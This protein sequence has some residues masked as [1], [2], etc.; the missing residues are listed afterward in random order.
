M[1]PDAY[2]RYYGNDF[3]SATK[4]W[5][6]EVKWAYWS[7]L[8]YYRSHTHCTG[9][10]D[11]NDFLRR[12]CECDA[13][14]WMRTKGLIFDN[15]RFF[16]LIDGKWHQLRAARD[17]ADDC[18]DYKKQCER[19]EKARA[20]NPDNQIGQ[21]R[22]KA[23][24]GS[25]TAPVTGPVTGQQPEPEPEPEPKEEQESFDKASRRGSSSSEKKTSNH[26]TKPKKLSER[27]KDIADK[28]EACLGDE[29]VN[30]AGKWIGRIKSDTGKAER[31]ANEVA[32]A[33]REGRIA[34]T[35]ARYAEDTWNRFK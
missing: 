14:D 5:R 34:T 15:D 27:Q 25:V 32:N 1:K 26:P 24:T 30:D 11:D 16:K 7:C 17:Y 35:P 3:E 12:L 31:V 19:T 6:P 13:A 2:S 18:A 29:W 23:V 4:G 21:Q 22:R 20:N 10:A 33:Q 28:F 8:W 9:L